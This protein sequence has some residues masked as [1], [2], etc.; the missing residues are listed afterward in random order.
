MESVDFTVLANYGAMGITLLYF[1]WRDNTT[2]KK[3][4]ETLQEVKEI[5][6]IFRAES[7]AKK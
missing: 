6:Q 1:I 2:M 4:T 3:F 7:G 5:I